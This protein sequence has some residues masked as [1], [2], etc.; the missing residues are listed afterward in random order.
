VHSR[1]SAGVESTLADNLREAEWAGLRTLCLVD[2]AGADSTWV[3]EMI[4]EV[5]ALRPMTDIDIR[6]GVEVDV[7]DV[8]GT[9]D[10]PWSRG[11]DHVLISAHDY[12]SATGPQAPEEVRASLVR[13]DVTSHDV[14]STL[15]EATVAAMSQTEHPIIAHPF[16]LMGRLGIPE[17]TITPSQV[18]HFA[19]SAHVTGTWVEVN[20]RWACPGPHLLREL[21]RHDVPLVAGSDSRRSETIGLYRHVRDAGALLAAYSK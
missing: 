8:N 2:H 15:V 14:V 17:S 12:P 3:N 9:L 4:D 10:L 21:V 5:R 19:R 7:M 20:E 16:S 11:V 13:G 6:C 18:R 1:Y